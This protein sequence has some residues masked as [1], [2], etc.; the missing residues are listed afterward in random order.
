MSTQ[1]QDVSNRRSQ[2]LPEPFRQSVETKGWNLDPWVLL[3]IPFAIGGIF[4]WEIF[5]YALIPTLIGYVALE[6][7]RGRRTPESTQEIGA[8]R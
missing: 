2:P 7:L 3:P 4:G 5:P 6:A 8:E 1:T